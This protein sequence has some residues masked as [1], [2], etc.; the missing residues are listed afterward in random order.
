M[1][2]KD[3]TSF[4]TSWMH[5]RGVPLLYNGLCDLKLDDW[6]PRNEWE[7]QAEDA[8]KPR[9]TNEAPFPGRLGHQLA[10]RVWKI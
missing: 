9:K 2:F 1:T 5:S 4:L 6:S 7:E 3:S 10:A 8:S